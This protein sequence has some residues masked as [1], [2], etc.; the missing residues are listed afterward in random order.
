MAYQNY[1]EISIE[2]S[3]L[4][5]HRV[6]RGAD[7]CL[8]EVAAL[9]QKR[10]WAEQ[11]ARKVAVDERR[12]ERE[13][14]QQELEDNQREAQERTAEAQAALREM[15]DIIAATLRVDDRVN[16]TAM[17]QPPFGQPRPKER[18]FLPLPSE[19]LFDPDGWKNR[20]SFVTALVPFLAKRAEIGARAEFSAAHAKWRERMEAAKITNERIYAENVRDFEDWQRRSEVYEEARAKYNASVEMARAAYQDLNA[21]A[22]LDY[23]DL[24]LSRSQYADCFPK[25]FELDYRPG[26][27]TLVADYR[28]PAPADLPHLESVKFSRTN[29]EFIETELPKRFR[30]V[31]QR[32]GLPNRHS[33]CA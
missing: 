17:I 14:K 28:L 16:W 8:V 15:R 25:E 1:Y 31:V 23:C 10:A 21:D 27:K 6:I 11:Y 22:I 33:H 26:T 29:S 4:N 5:K 18:P 3:G 7:R 30:T 32:R 13:D 9:T 12:R 19:P 20:K 24:V 2:H